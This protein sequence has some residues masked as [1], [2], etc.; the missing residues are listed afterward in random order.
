M[1]LT[2]R[3]ERLY[4][5]TVDIWRQTTGDVDFA[6]YEKV[7]T[8]VACY[9]ESTPEADLVSAVGRNKQV[10][11]L[12]MDLFHFDIAETIEDTDYLQMV[13]G[14]GGG[15]V[16]NWWAVQGNTRTHGYRANKQVVY[17]KQSEIPQ[18]GS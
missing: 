2:A 4:V 16:G 9:F 7:G 8:A 18:G 6:P 17:A 10:N 1:A 3:Q 15:L 11:I 12:T 13:S 14:P 5:Y